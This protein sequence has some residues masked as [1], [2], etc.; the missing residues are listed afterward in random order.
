M[1]INKAKEDEE[2]G[3]KN[4]FSSQ[5]FI[6]VMDHL[7]Q[8]QL[9]KGIRLSSIACTSFI[10]FLTGMARHGAVSPPLSNT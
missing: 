1:I 3:K 9:H 7:K 5:Q 2:K 8:A 4:V 10:R 6:P